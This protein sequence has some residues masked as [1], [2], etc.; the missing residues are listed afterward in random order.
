VAATQRGDAVVRLADALAEATRGPRILT[1]DIETGPHMARVFS[2]FDQNISLVQLEEVSTVMCFAAKWLDERK[3][4]FYSDHHDGHDAMIDAAWSLMDEADAI[5]SYNGRAFDCKH[6]HREFILAGM[7]PPSPH[8][9]IDLL[10]V[11]RSRAKFAS[12]KLD[13]VA[14]ELGLGSKTKHAGFEMWRDCLNG[15]EKAWKKFRQYNIQDVKLTEAL[16]Y[17]LLPWIKNHPHPGLYP[18][19]DLTGCPNCGGPM[20]P[21]GRTTNTGSRQYA[22]LRCAACGAN[23]R[24]ARAT[25]NTTTGTRAV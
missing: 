21:T 12:G 11:V 13:H 22:L 5:V 9:D 4:M 18:G 1:I 23:G 24:P 8:K 10:T 17:R 15:D 6:L 16:Y 19:G 7:P 20:A 14:S 25:P 2:L 3:V